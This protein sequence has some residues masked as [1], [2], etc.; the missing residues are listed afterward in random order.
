M[1][2]RGECHDLVVV[3]AEH[4]TTRAIFKAGAIAMDGQFASWWMVLSALSSSY[5]YG[6]AAC[7][8]HDVPTRDTRIHD[9][10]LCTDRRGNKVGDRR[11]GKPWSEI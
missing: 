6:M 10:N 1:D 3:A 9:E 4:A 7:G 8:H 11:F 2:G 5:L